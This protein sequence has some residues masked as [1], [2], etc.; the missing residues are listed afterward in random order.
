[1]ISS[2]SVPNPTRPAS[3]QQDR[4]S[5]LWVSSKLGMS[6]SDTADSPRARAADTMYVLLVARSEHSSGSYQ[7]LEANTWLALALPHS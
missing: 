5:P 3:R 7:V 4:A 6:F 1:M 2:L